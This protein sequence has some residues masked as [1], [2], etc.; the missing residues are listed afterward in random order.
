MPTSPKGQ[1]ESRF[2]MNVSVL[3]FLAYILIRSCIEFFN[4]TWG[5]GLWLGE[6]SLKWGLVFFIFAIFCILFF[7]GVT[8]F[9]VN[10]G[11]N[12]FLSQKLVSFRKRVGLF[13]WGLIV[14]LIIFPQIVL[15]LPSLMFG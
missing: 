7:V 14:I 9:L 11:F 15:W 3:L 13:R 4:I 12:N 8:I 5:T 2:A 10:P 1:K 6:F